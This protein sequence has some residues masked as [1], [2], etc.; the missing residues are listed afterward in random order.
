VFACG[1][2]WP[3]AGDWTAAEWAA[4]RDGQI[5]Y[6][7]EPAAGP[8]KR[9]QLVRSRVALRCEEAH[10]FIRPLLAKDPGY[11]NDGS[12]RQAAMSNFVS[13]V[14]A[15]RLSAAKGHALG[16]QA[17]DTE[18]WSYAASAVRLPELLAS[19]A[20]LGAMSHPDG[21]GDAVAMIE[22][23]NASVAESRRWTVLPFKGRFIK[24]VDRT[25]YGRLLVV[26]P[27]DSRD[28]W[29]SFA[30]ATPDMKSPPE[31]RSVSVVAI[32]RTD[33]GSRAYLMDFLRTRRGS[34]GPIELMP[35]ALLPDNP[36]KN[37][38]DCHKAAVLPVHPESEYV[39]DSSG[40]LVERQ[41]GSA[42]V[43]AQVNAR[44]RAYGK[45]DFGPQ[46]T[47]AYGPS[48]GTFRERGPAWVRQMAGSQLSDASVARVIEAMACA[49]CH[50]AFAPLNFPEG[51][52]TD[53]ETKSMREKRGLA[54]AF[55]EDGLMPPGNTL[56]PAERRAL[57][58][59]LSADYFDPATRDG[60]LVEWL[61]GKVEG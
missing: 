26:V 37:C 45:A 52:R 10:R 2:A 13:F 29:V 31:V 33:G 17:S 27:E 59:C 4:W 20:F 15:Q 51:V 48:L 39:F 3:G 47:A 41:A 36:S 32:E 28:L 11:F 38:Y 24:S 21:Y 23:R 5:A 49:K 14:E 58:Q 50:D 60:A 16:M 1:A 55:V 22:A 19:Q 42:S 12:E 35:T 54:Q 8:D 56:T 43:A 34:R 18:Y 61:R 7:L 53:R 9:P 44:I 57:W 40:A 46:D 25:T 6:I 30:I